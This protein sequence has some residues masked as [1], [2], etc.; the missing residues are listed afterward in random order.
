MEKDTGLTF[1]K[2]DGTINYDDT[3][4]VKGCPVIARLVKLFGDNWQEF[5]C[6]GKKQRKNN[7][8]TDRVFHNV[9]YTA[10]SIWNYCFTAE[11]PEEVR[12]FAIECLE[13][14]ERKSKKLLQ[15]W[16]DMQIGYAMLSQ[17]AMKNNLRFL[18]L[19][20][21]YPDAVLLAKVPDL[22]STCGHTINEQ[23]LNSIILKYISDIKTKNTELKTYAIIANSLISS[24]KAIDPSEWH[25]KRRNDYLLQDDDIAKVEEHCKAHYGESKWQMFS[26]EERTKV[27][28]EVTERYQSFFASIDRDFVRVPKLSDDIFNYLK[29]V[30][31]ALQ[32]ADRAKLYHP[33][34]ISAYRPMKSTDSS[35][36]VAQLGSPN[37]GSI[38]NPVALRTLNIL[39]DKINQMLSCRMIDP[40]DTR[41]VIETTREVGDVLDDAN[42]RTAFTHYQTQ[43]ANERAAIEKILSVEY[44]QRIIDNK[45]IDKALYVIEQHEHENWQTPYLRNEGK[46]KGTFDRTFSKYILKYKLWL[47]QGC[48]CMYTGRHIN[49]SNLFDDNATDIEHTIPRSL[50]FDN[51]DAN[52]TVCDAYYNKHVKKNRIPTQM[53]NYSHAANGYPAIEPMLEKW[54]IKVKH[55]EEKVD[56]WKHRSS[57]AQTKE[58]KDYA[59]VNRHEWEAEL[60]YWTDKLD[61]FTRTDIPEKFRN[62]QLVDTG[63]IT[64]HALAYLKS[65]FTNVVAQ[66]GGVTAVFRDILG[67]QGVEKKKTGA[68]IPI[69]QLMLLCSP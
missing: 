7:A 1:S 25:D 3:V 11:E 67:L 45:D 16:D 41:I 26:D 13:W 36:D 64:R 58:D 56:Y 55:L 49:I 2:D 60:K 9:V 27:M 59:I 66:K 29:S 15:L 21:R 42:A 62:S 38:K 50:C 37:M 6:P 5:T 14:D 22:L 31:P 48:R 8:H 39:K 46:N 52:L 40:E 44:P 28:T 61:R 18:R 47:E 24:F 65:V 20:L 35:N 17:K 63:V 51:S 57:R 23:E 54:K 4:R 69:M 34:M 43:R 12:R 10:E 30:C 32:D 68:Y 19:G 53:E 33:S